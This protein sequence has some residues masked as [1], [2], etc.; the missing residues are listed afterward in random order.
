M[1]AKYLFKGF[2]KSIPGIEHVYNF[3]KS[4]GGTNNARYC[5]SVWMRHLLAAQENGMKGVPKRIAELGPGDSLG[6]GLSALISG[7]E[8][9]YALDVVRY[10]NVKCNL[11]IFDELVKMF[12][13]K[14]PI[15]PEAEFPNLRPALKEHRFPWQILS[16]EHLARVLEPSRIERI[17]RSIEGIENMGGQKGTDTMIRYCV[18]W[19]DENVVEPGGVDMIIS[20]AVLQHVNDLEGTYKAMHKWLKDDGIMSHSIDL[21]S[22]GS[23]DRWDGHWTYT[24]MEWKIVKGRKNYLINREPYSTHIRLLKENGFR[25]V[26]D[27]KSRAVSTLHDGKFA[28]PRFKNLSEEDRTISGTFIQAIKQFFISLALFGEE[29]AG[30]VTAWNIY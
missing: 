13:E 20:Q 26:C 9:Y 15:P 7:A 30:M 1:K 19:Y 14:S 6:I 8:Q 29:F 10:T 18:P 25:V 23:S 28:A 21:K 17:R 12:S 27:R 3:H 22:M 4:T 16:D 5:Y 11:E 2:F 24:E